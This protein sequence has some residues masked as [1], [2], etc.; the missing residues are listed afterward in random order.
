MSFS[1]TSKAD[2]TNPSPAEDQ[3]IL[4]EWDRQ[5]TWHPF[6]QTSEMKHFPPLRITGGDGC[7]L[8]DADGNRYLDGQI[9]P[10]F[11]NIVVASS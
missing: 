5:Y 4:D 11:S 2:A 1:L 9:D 6:A 8:N 7:W 3:A 10:I